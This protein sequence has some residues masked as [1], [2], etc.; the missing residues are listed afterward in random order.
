MP[1]HGKFGLK[2]DRPTNRVL[3]HRR[4]GATDESFH[5]RQRETNEKR[6]ANR[7]LNELSSKV[8]EETEARFWATMY[9]QYLMKRIHN[10]ERIFIEFKDLPDIKRLSLGDE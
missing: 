9:L 4:I 7:I 1:S 3:I 6:I 2:Y 8:R 10:T 5:Q